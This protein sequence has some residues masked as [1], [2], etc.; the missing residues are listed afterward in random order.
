MAYSP[1]TQRG[2]SSLSKKLENTTLDGWS[3]GALKRSGYN[4]LGDLA[5]THRDTLIK[6]VAKHNTRGIGNR[7]MA[8]VDDVMAEHDLKVSMSLPLDSHKLDDLVAKTEVSRKASTG[9]SFP[10][11]TTPPAPAQPADGLDT[12]GLQDVSKAAIDLVKKLRDAGLIT[13]EQIES[14]I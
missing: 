9:P 1:L 7:G 10:I 13:D 8:N 14:L 4:T 3:K 12:D 6:D 11:F 2:R 5:R